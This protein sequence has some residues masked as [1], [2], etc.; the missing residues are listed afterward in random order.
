MLGIPTDQHGDRTT[1]MRASDLLHVPSRAWYEAKTLVAAHPSLALPLARARGHGY[2][3]GP[4]TE[5]VIE[6]FPRSATSFAVSAFELAQPVKPDIAHHV[7]AP[8]QLIVAARAGIPALLL[9]RRPADAVLS[10]AVR[11]PE[12][13]AGGMLRGW[14]RFHE[15]LLSCRS[16]LVVATFDQVV[17][18]FG[19]VME[20][21]NQRFGTS[22]VPFEHTPENVE[23]VLGLI[24]D[25]T[26]PP[27]G[28]EGSVER[29]VSRPSDERAGAREQVRP[30]YLA[31]KLAAT[32]V[33]AE[34]LY[35]DFARD[36]SG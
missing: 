15:P 24:E 25:Y 33:R 3:V 14:V 1:P 8:A 17:T 11:E 5:L 10:L 13:S 30:A 36:A 20:R 19:R 12:R 31:P 23:R 6:G 34:T 22:F 29:I 16:G 21:V 2:P 27:E 32:R 18:D 26:R 7:H 9:I 35:E 28:D 4:G